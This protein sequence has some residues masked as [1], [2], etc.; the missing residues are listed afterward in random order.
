M[1]NDDIKKISI[2]EDEIKQIV[3]RLGTQIS[4]DY[5][6]RNPLFIGLLKGCIP[7]MISSGGIP[8]ITRTKFWSSMPLLFA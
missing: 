7:F 3:E 1:M 5:Q 8:E 6:G 2:S 4:K